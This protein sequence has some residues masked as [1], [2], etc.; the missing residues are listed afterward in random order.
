M[1][2]IVHK[3]NIETYWYKTVPTQRR[4]QKASQ[5]RITIRYMSSFSFTKLSDNL[6]I[7]IIKLAFNSK[8]TRLL[9]IPHWII[10]KILKNSGTARHLSVPSFRIGWGRKWTWTR[11]GHPPSLVL[12]CVASHSMEKVGQLCPIILKIFVTS[13]IYR[14]R[15]RKWKIYTKMVLCICWN[16]FPQETILCFRLATLPYI[17]T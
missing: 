13:I 2:T 8:A 16:W 6:Q 3:Q 7:F 17:A 11:M 12:G 10:F 1:L 14:K 9:I 5:L 15:G 4:L